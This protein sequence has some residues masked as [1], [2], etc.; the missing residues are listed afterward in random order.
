MKSDKHDIGIGFVYK[1]L[2]SDITK[3]KHME[4]IIPVERVNSHK[5][6]QQGTIQCT[7]PG[8]CK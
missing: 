5:T 6:A 4:Q 2:R 3:I 8:T 7:V 1:P